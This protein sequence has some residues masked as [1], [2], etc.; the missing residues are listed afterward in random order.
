MESAGPENV[1][2]AS[3]TF[4]WVPPAIASQRRRHDGTEFWNTKSLGERL[5]T[6]VFNSVTVWS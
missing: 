1:V 4:A 2:S 3:L 6:C 5:P